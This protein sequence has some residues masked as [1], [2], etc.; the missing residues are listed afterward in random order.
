MKRIFILFILLLSFNALYSADFVAGFVGRIGGSSATT[1]RSKVFTSN[2]RDFDN[3]FSFQPGV[4]W[5]YDDFLSAAL[6][7]DIGYSKDRYEI[8]YTING[9]RVLENYNFG[10]FSIG[11]FPRFNVGFFSIGFGGGIKL[12]LSLK[13][14]KEG[15][16]FSKNRY[17]LDFG[18]IQDA[19]TTSYIPYI[20]VSADF[21]IKINRKFM[22]SLGVYA[23]YD[24]PI[25]I[26][27]NGIFKDFTINQDSLASFD[28]GFQIGMYFLSR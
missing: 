9:K 26:D 14:T 13:Y 25:D 1:D 4:F 3:S 16:E 23:N 7:L 19:F 2:F 18:D 22:M 21:L 28:I 27:K 20:K 12:P 17:S 8:K 10:S 6:L 11:V 15:D 24:F 5:G